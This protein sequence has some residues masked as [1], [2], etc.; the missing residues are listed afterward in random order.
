MKLANDVVNICSA[1]VK[2]YSRHNAF[3]SYGAYN[4]IVS[5]LMFFTARAFNG[6]LA[7]ELVILH[8]GITIGRAIKSITHTFLI[9]DQS[10]TSFNSVKGTRLPSITFFIFSFSSVGDS[11]DEPILTTTTSALPL[12][13]PYLR[14]ASVIFRINQYLQHYLKA[15]CTTYVMGRIK[16]IQDLRVYSF[17][18]KLAL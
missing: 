1:V 5:N 14:M 11:S 3:H 10:V 13:I 18:A 7:I 12:E 16:I 4:Y 6:R 9:D 2:G 15:K 17:R 8:E